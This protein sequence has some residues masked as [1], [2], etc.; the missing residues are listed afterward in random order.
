MNGKTSTDPL[1]GWGNKGGYVYQKV[2][3]LFC[4]KIFILI[5][6]GFERVLVSNAL[7]TENLALELED[8]Q[9]ILN[10]V[11]CGGGNLS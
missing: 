7:T 11:L 4:E 8:K 9:Y 3:R 5:E 2:S 6:P 10:F 1:V